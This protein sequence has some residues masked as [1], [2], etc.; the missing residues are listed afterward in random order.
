MKIK[1]L[2]LLSAIV[3]L[4]GCASGSKRMVDLRLNY[5]PGGAPI[6][7]PDRNAQAQV[8]R[9]AKSVDHS[10]QELSAIQQATHSRV[11]MPKPLNPKASGMTRVASLSWN[12]PV[13]PVVRRIAKASGYRLRVL[14]NRPAVPVIINIEARNQILAD[15]LRNV[16]YQAQPNATIRVYPKSRVIELRY[17]Q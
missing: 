14:G 4:A 15:I 5:V 12:G 1:Y 7:S 9:T 16:R 3:L 8:A 2:L 13:E 10:L 6:H 17:K 11:K